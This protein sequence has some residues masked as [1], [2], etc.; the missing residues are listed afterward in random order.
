[1]TVRL[2][3]A[4]RA[5]R[6]AAPLAALPWEE[7]PVLAALVRSEDGGPPE[8]ATAVRACWDGEALYARWECADREAWG[9]LTGRDAPI[10]EEEVVELFLAPGAEDP[11]RYVEFEVAPTGVFFD[12]LIGNPNRRR[13]GLEIGTEWDCAG[14]VWE[15]GELP[16]RAAGAQDWWAALAVPWRGVLGAL[17]R[18]PGE[19]PPVWR[20]NFY[21]IDRPRDGAPE[22]SAWSPTLVAPADFHRPAR[23]GTWVLSA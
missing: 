13:A 18:P 15:A 10:Y 21:R 5:F 4:P 9:T 3:R 8:Q 19:L 14:V 11:G 23:F 7:V 16:E 1:M 17:G 12:A 2:P 20:A 6:P 22:H